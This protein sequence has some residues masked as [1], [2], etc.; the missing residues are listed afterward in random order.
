MEAKLVVTP[1]EAGVQG[2][3]VSAA[4]DSRFRGNDESI[5]LNTGLNRNRSQE[6]PFN[7]FA[8]KSNYHQ[9]TVTNQRRPRCSCE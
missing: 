7:P 2:Q 4:L 6:S 8:T 3:R 1:A 9:S 5:R